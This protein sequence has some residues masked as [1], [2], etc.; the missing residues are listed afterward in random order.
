VFHAVD[1]VQAGVQ[2]AAGVFAAV[3]VVG[4][5]VSV[6]LPIETMGR[7][8]PEEADDWAATSKLEHAVSWA[9][10][11]NGKQAEQVAANETTSKAGNSANSGINPFSVETLG[12]SGAATAYTDPYA[13]SGE[14]A[15]KKKA[16]RS[17]L[18]SFA[19]AQRS[20]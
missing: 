11:G 17:C 16:V 2:A 12:S 20:D 13:I 15:K 9:V 5:I 18:R 3:S 19:S 8:L 4:A 14:A 10:E 7:E 1:G 6:F